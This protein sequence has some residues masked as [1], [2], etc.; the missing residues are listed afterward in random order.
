MRLSGG[1][2]GGAG[3][4]I[5]STVV[6]LLGIPIPVGVLYALGVLGVGMMAWPVVSGG[7]KYLRGPVGR[8]PIK[9]SLVKDSESAQIGVQT[10][11]NITFVQ[12]A[13]EVKRSVTKCRARIA[14]IE[15]AEP[16]SIF[17]VEHNEAR[18]SRWSDREQ[19]EID[20]RPADP[21][22]RCNIATFDAEKGLRLYPRT[23]TN[24][25]P[26]LQ[27][28]GTHRFHLHIS[29]ECDGRHV[30][31]KARVLIDWRGSN[32]AFVRLA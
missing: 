32:S 24:L 31:E 25:I 7:S 9:L 14:K 17:A 5:V 28:H 3:L 2:I 23:P 16:G 4:T 27:R 18:D 22:T 26:K 8:S 21:P 20:L 15:Y 13:V 12:V 19:L 1:Q 6:P 10:F 29:G 11:P 30:L